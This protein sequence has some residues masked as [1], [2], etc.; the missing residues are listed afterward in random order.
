M[1]DFSSDNKHIRIW[2]SYE[3]VA[4]LLMSRRA[5]WSY[6]Y[7]ATENVDEEGKALRGNPDDPLDLRIDTSGGILHMHYGTREPHLRQSDIGG[8]DLRDVGAIEFIRGVIRHRTRGDDFTKI[9]GFKIKG[10]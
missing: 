10:T 5:Q 7:G 6:H 9:F 1:L 4:G 3:K 2:E 8:L